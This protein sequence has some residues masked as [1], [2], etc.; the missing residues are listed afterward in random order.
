MLKLCKLLDKTDDF[1]INNIDNRNNYLK[2]ISPEQ[3]L[4]DE[5]I[6]E[7]L[8]GFKTNN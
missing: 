3:L 5:K 1:C 8:I 4:E 2:N 7:E 6:I